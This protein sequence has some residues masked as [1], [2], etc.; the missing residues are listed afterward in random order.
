MDENRKLAIG[1]YKPTKK[2][3]EA[4]SHIAVMFNDDCTLVAITGYADDEKNVNESIDY[5]RLFAAAPELL[6]ACKAAAEVLQGY[7]LRL[8]QTAIKK[9]E[10]G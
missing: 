3:R 10:E 8:I 2:F 5:A 1:L 6:K 7:R 9:A 4:S